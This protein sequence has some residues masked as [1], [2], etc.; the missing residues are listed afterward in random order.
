MI[1]TRFESIGVHVP[2]KKVSTAE[3]ISQMKNQPEFSLEEVTGIKN[4]LWAS[5]KETSFTMGV[6]S[7][8]NCL[9]KSSYKAEDLD[10]IISC[11]IA[12]FVDKKMMHYEPSMSLM[13]KRAIGADK[14]ICFDV[15]NACAGMFSGLLILDA[16]IKSGAVKNGMVVSGE[17]I[18]SIAETAVLEV[19]DS[20]DPQFGSLTVGDSGAALILDQAIDDDDVIEEIELLSTSEYSH[21]AIG[22][23]SN[24]SNMFAMYAS[25]SKMHSE[26]R[27][28]IWPN[29]QLDTQ[30][31][32]KTSFTSQRYDYIIQHQV[33]M[34]F[35]KKLL[36]IGAAAFG[37]E[38]PE[39]LAVLN[40]YGNTSSTSHFMVLHDQLEKKKYKPGAK[41]LFVPAGSGF[42]TGFMSAKITKLAV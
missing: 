17:E 33:G 15:S 19:K 5:E 13:I 41:V 20:Y 16:M 2:A 22:M 36:K 42:V 40:E 7:A 31:K 10:I 30:Q 23:P 35:I 18:S 28:Q 11:S 14:A 32:M 3:L 8:K 24:E 37:T 12:R 29:F 25:N 1:K 6:D 26:E 9:K 21:L 27:L 38:M 4:R 34:K 39:S